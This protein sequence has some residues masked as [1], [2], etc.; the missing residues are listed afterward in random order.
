MKAYEIS[1][2]EGCGIVV[3]AESRG[4]AASIAMHDE[5]FEDYSF[6]DIKPYRAPEFDKC[7][8]GL[9]KMD[10]YDTKD[11]IAF[12]KA[13]WYC[14]DGCDYKKCPAKEYCQRYIEKK[15]NEI[16]RGAERGRWTDWRRNNNAEI[17]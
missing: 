12:C 10:W 8:R 1:N 16:E 2:D 11:R 9:S 14:I 5:I 3:F 17:H 13:G 4:K 15:Y 7:Y 6:V